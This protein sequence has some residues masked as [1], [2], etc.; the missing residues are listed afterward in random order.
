[1]FQKKWGVVEP[2]ERLGVQFD[3]KWNKQSYLW[4]G[5][6]ERQFYYIQILETIQCMCRNSDICELLV[7][8]N[9]SKINR[10]E[11]CDESYFKTPPLFSKQQ[12]SLQIRKYY[13]DFE[14]G[15]KTQC[16]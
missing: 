13:D 1:M 9:V 6:S 3:M 4:S 10:Y 14:A 15:F 8:P 11:D 7:E 5:P 12:T 16:S 2:V